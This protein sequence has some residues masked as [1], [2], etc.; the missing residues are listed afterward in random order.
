M[1]DAI[2]YEAVIDLGERNSSHTM[3][4]ELAI[5]SG[6]PS[7][8]IL[9]VGCSS[10]Y[11]GA[12][13]V[14][15]GH[16]VAGVEPDAPSAQAAR[17]RLTEVYTGGFDAFLDAHPDRSFDV[18]IFGDVLEHLV[19]PVDALRRARRQL[20]PDGRIV[21]SVPNV[22]HGSVRAMLLEGRWDYADKGILDHTHL[23]FFSRAGV[24]RMLA[25]AGLA[26]ERLHAVS[27]PADVAGRDYAMHLQRELVTAAELLDADGSGAAFQY[28]LLARPDDA[29]P[30]ELLASN[31]AVDCRPV[32]PL[33]RLPGSRSLRQRLQVALFRH[34]LRQI[35]RR[36]FRGR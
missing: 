29:P 14:A 19:D 18:I 17:A 9:E 1:K 7:L 6:R 10:G 31:L 30:G 3:L 24:A 22:A 4:H 15:K 27:L 21:V 2:K 5:A 26:L 13:L 11:L 32:V 28:V 23:R 36:R 33:R 16:R 34:L 35:S 8:D 20:R 25:D 12:T